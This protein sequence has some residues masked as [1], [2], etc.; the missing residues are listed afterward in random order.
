MA[1][2][3]LP[4]II[5]NSQSTH[6]GFVITPDGLMVP[7]YVDAYETLGVRVRKLLSDRTV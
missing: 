7:A 4:S 5:L 1:L 2:E 3:K 6:D